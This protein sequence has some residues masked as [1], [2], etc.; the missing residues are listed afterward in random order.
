MSEARPVV[1]LARPGD[2]A[3]RP[4]DLHIGLTDLPL[5]EYGGRESVAGKTVNP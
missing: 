3:Y 4:T 1:C 5:A 2:I